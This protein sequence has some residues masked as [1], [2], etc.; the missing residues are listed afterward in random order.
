MSMFLDSSRTLPDT[1]E[2]LGN[3]DMSGILLDSPT[4]LLSWPGAR[5]AGAPADRGAS[6][7]RWCRARAPTGEIRKMSVHTYSKVERMVRVTLCQTMSP[8]RS[9]VRDARDFE[10]RAG[11]PRAP[12]T[13]LDGECRIRMRWSCRSA[14][15]RGRDAADPR[16]V[17]AT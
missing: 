15:G 5:T 4:L 13:E 9:C 16:S 2:G 17:H 1:K 6:R 14:C 3:P 8:Q 10:C 11:Y 7:R 12:E